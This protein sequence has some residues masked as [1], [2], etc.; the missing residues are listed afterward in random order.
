MTRPLTTA[1]AIGAVRTRVNHA[2][3]IAQAGIW[4]MPNANRDKGIKSERDVAAY[5]RAHGMLGAE[6]SVSTGW[7][8]RGRHLADVGDIKGIPGVCVQVRNVVRQ[9]P[10]GLAGKALLE[11]LAETRI[12]GQAAGAA[13]AILIEKRAGHADVG[14]WWV[15][16]PANLMAALLIGADPYSFPLCTITYPIRLEMRHIVK[17]LAEFS[18]MCSEVAA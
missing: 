13:L 1:A 10:K 2:V 5:C 11:M 17:S 15:H 14:E 16:I 3:K 18:A 7:K 6:R 4:T 9:H 8:T 12:Q